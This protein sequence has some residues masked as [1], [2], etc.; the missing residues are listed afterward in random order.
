MHRIIYLLATFATPLLGQQAGTATAET[1]PTLTIYKCTTSG[2]C[3]AQTAKLVLNANWRW[4]HGPAPNYV[5][6][7]DTSL[8]SLVMRFHSSDLNSSY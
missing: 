2:G 4:L 5:K 8:P 3:I 1:H 6:Y 7:V